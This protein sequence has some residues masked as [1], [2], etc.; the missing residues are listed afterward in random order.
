[1]NKVIL[2]GNCT[3]DV[4]IR[5]TQAGKPVASFSLATNERYKDK[6]GE[7]V[8]KPTFH[9]IVVFSE[10]LARI[11]DQYVKKGTLLYIE[12]AIEN[13]SWDDKETGQKRYKTEILLSG[14]NATLTML[15]NKQQSN[16]VSDNQQSDPYRQ[17]PD[18]NDIDGDIPF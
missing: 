16:N 9:N 17:R 2:V 8:D 15:G 10:G 11:C 4:T 5:H 6:N 13:S 3:N 14:F 12:G 18:H 1:M 7:R